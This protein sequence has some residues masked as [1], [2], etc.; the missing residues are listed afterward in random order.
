MDVPI[1]VCGEVQAATAAQGGVTP[2]WMGSMG[3]F[4]A[5]RR[6]RMAG[7]EAEHVGGGWDCVVSVEGGR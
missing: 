4:A 5:M 6:V 2:R 7:V 3:L 1:R